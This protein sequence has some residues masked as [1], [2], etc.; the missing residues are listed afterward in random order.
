MAIMP[1][2]VPLLLVLAAALASAEYVAIGDG[3]D[4]KQTCPDDWGI[5]GV[6][7]WI[8]GE[9]TI[10]AGS[11]TLVFFFSQSCHICHDVAPNLQN[12]YKKMRGRGLQIIG[13]HSTP[14]GYKAKDEDVAALKAWVDEI[15]LEF[16]IVDTHSKEG[17]QPENPDGTPDYQAATMTRTDP[18]SLS[19]F[20]PHFLHFVLKF[21]FN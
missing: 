4:K 1:A 10:D 12:L 2:K 18:D 6:D 13:V 3:G 8:Q 9:T 11:L 16:S 15:G 5:T 14:K 20:Y 21:P 19:A 7:E 17:E